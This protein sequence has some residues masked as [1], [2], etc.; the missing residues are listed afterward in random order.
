MESGKPQARETLFRCGG[1][2][3]FTTSVAIPMLS[4]TTSRTATTIRC[5][6]PLR[7]LMALR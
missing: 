1:P 6:S 4:V 3:N 2:Q 5:R 7:S